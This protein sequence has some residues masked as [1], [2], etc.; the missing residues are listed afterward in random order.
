MI[1][2]VF[3]LLQTVPTR[4]ELVDEVYQV[5]SAEWRY[6]AISVP[7]QP[8]IIRCHFDA[9]SAKTVVRLA[10]LRKAELERFRQGQ[11]HGFLA[12]TEASSSGS[13][14]RRVDAPGE[15]ALV[16]QNRGQGGRIAHVHLRVSLDLVRASEP[17]V[18]TL[19]PRRRLVVVTISLVVFFAIVLISGA[20]LLRFIRTVR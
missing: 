19:P 18:R 13:L 11:P 5:P 10:L 15:Y 6:L 4:V 20:R 3:L 2:A 1:L 17:A 8:A 14:E 16:I 7:R 9:E 12:V